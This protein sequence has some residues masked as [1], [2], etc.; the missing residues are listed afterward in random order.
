MAQ[1]GIKHSRYPIQLIGSAGIRIT[2]DRVREAVRSVG[3]TVGIYL[4][5][6]HGPPEAL[7]AAARP[8]TRRG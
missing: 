7:M 5:I 4:P 2:L 6:S 8:L 1:L 3:G